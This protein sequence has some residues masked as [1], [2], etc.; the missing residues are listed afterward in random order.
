MR[1]GVDV[2]VSL[3]TVDRVG[4]FAGNNDR[5]S[6]DPGCLAGISEGGGNQIYE[7]VRVHPCIGRSMHVGSGNISRQIR[8]LKIER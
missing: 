1:C 5:T 3:S 6:N 8:V 2:D 4:D 7:N